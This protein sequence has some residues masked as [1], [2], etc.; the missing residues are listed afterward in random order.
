MKRPD[1]YGRGA[2]L[3]SGVPM[4]PAAPCRAA[5]VDGLSTA[6]EAFA[7]QEQALRAE[8]RAHRRAALPSLPGP[9]CDAGPKGFARGPLEAIAVA[10]V[11]CDPRTGEATVRAGRAVRRKG[12]D[13]LATL[14]EALQQAAREYLALAEM[15]ASVRAPGEGPRGGLSDGGAAARCEWSLK[16][17][18]CEDAIRGD[19]GPGMV[20]AARGIHAQA[21]RGRRS[22]RILELVNAVALDGLSVTAVLARWGWSRGPANDRAVRDALRAALDRLAAFLGLATQDA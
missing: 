22:L 21:D 2:A 17:R 19:D 20:L 8:I 3:L 9:F 5:T 18:E 13:A 15:V 14:P 10:A 12:P 1:D 4:T 6:G 11:E 7:A 16:L